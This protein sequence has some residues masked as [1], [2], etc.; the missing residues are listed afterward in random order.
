[1]SA[2]MMP[3]ETTAIIAEYLAAA[4]SSAGHTG[5]IQGIKTIEPSPTLIMDL[6]HAGCYDADRDEFSARK[7]YD[8]LCE[9]NSKALEAQYGNGEDAAPFASQSID[10]REKTRRKWL[11][12]L[13]T[14]ARCYRYQCDEGDVGKSDFLKAFSLWVDELAYTLA[15]FTVEAVRP[16][17]GPGWKSWS[18]F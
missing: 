6:R 18:E 10:T 8:L 9:Y 14:V 15:A 3:A 12:N 1:M 17:F 2:Y 4:A 5:V 13:F 16:K 7:V 11:S